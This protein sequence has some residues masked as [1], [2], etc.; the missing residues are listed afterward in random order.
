[1][2]K[3]KDNTD[4]GNACGGL[5]SKIQFT[6]LVQKESDEPYVNFNFRILNNL[7]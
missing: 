4:L 6:K 1:M 2:K 5:D 7:D 3:K